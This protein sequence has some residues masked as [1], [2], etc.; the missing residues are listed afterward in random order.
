MLQIAADATETVQVIDL[1][2]S[3]RALIAGSIGNL[4]EWYEFAIYGYMAPYIARQFFPSDTPLAAIMATFM[5]FALAFFMRPIGAVIFGRLTD[6]IGRRP[7]LV[8]I[9]VLMTVATTLIGLLPTAATI[10]GWAAVLLV[11]CRI[12]QGLS[13]GGEMGGAVSLMVENAPAD[14]RGLYGSWSFVGTVF[15]FVLGGAMATALTMA[16]SADTMAAWGWRVPFLL[17]LPMGAIA[18]YIRTKVDETPHFKR[19]QARRLGAGHALAPGAIKYTAGYL[20]VTAGVVIVY[21]AVGNV[22][23]VG[24]PT[25]LSRAF[26]VPPVQAYFLTLVTGLVGGLSMPL[27]GALSDRVGR[28]PVLLAGAVGTLVLSYPL[29]MLMGT[30]FNGGL[31]ALFIAGVLIGVTG[32]PLPAFLSERFPTRHRGM[33][34][35]VVYAITVAIFGGS[36]PYVITWILQVTGDPLAAA[37]YTTL[38]GLISVVAMLAWHAGQADKRIEHLAPLED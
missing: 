25:Y 7:V 32:G 18:L 26:Q 38:C 9:I 6:K 1:R 36:S 21:N 3:S 4:I 37:Y 33:G 10:G 34:V 8:S 2:A 30:G 11:I 14:K 24:M 16:L 35:A 23:M 29:Y 22:F 20:L 5:V 12:G 17:A 19:V 27:F 28:R 31:L 15:G 13:G